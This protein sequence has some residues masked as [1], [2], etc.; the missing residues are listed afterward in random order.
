MTTNP[1]FR[2]LF[3]VLIALGLITIQPCRAGESRVAPGNWSELSAKA[4]AEYQ[5]N[6]LLVSPTKNGARLN[7]IFQKLEGEVTTKGLWLSSKAFTESGDRF[8]V[9]ARSFG[10][11][12]GPMLNLS[13]A[14][15]VQIACKLVRFARENLI[16][17]YST[18]IDGI[19]QDFI[20]LQK[21]GG[22]GDLRVDLAVS[23]A[24][25]ETAPDG[26]RL[27]LSNSGRRIMYGQVQ[28]IDAAGKLLKCRIQQLSDHRIAALIDDSNALYPIRVDP[29]FSDENWI[30]ANF[31]P[32]VKANYAYA[33]TTDGAGNVYVGGGAMDVAGNAVAN[34]VAK[35]D[36]TRWSGL[37]SG[38]TDTVYAL[39]TVG[40][41]VYAG[42]VFTSAGG[43]PAS[44]IAKWDGTAWSAVGGGFDNLVHSLV[45]DNGI[46]Y[47][48]GYFSFATNSGTPVST[49]YIAKWDGNNWSAVGKGL[50]A[51]VDA[52]TVLSNSIYPVGQFYEATNANNSVLSTLRI[53]RWD[54]TNW[55]ALGS[56]LNGYGYSV[57]AMAG[58]I[59]VGGEFTTAGGN[60]AKNVAKW[61]GSSWS[62][63]GTGLN[64][65]V[66]GLAAA[67]TTLYAGG[68]FTLAGATSVSRMAKWDGVSWSALET[69]VENTV[70]SLAAFGNNVYAAGQFRRAGTNGVSMVAKWNG[71]WSA[72]GSGFNHT[73]N[74]LMISQ[75]EIYASGNFTTA[76]GGVLASRIAK[77]N[78]TT[79]SPL[80]PGIDN[81][82]GPMIMFQNRLYV[83]GAI[84]SPFRNLGKWDGTNW[85]SVGGGVSGIVSA[86]H[87]IGNNLYVSGQF[88]RVTNSGAGTGLNVSRIARW[89]GTNWFSLNGGVDNS[90]NSL[91]SNGSDLYLGGGFLNGTNGN[92]PISLTRV[93]KWDGT[94]FSALGGG[95]DGAPLTMAAWKNDIYFGGFFKMATN[96]GN[97][98]GVSYAAKWNGTSFVALGAGLSSYVA[99]TIVGPGGV[100]FAGDFAIATNTAGPVLVNRIARWDGNQWWPLGSG[101]NGTV[102]C[103]ATSGQYLYA[104]GAFGTAGGKGSAYFAKAQVLSPAVVAV[105]VFK[106]N[107]IDLTLSGTPNEEYSIE[108][109][110]SLGSTWTP[111]GTVT[112]DTNGVATFQDTSLPTGPAFYRAVTE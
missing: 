65:N 25:V 21:A 98:V 18:S 91:T 87:V 53:A 102:G 8:Q 106:T 29:T 48:G 92:T 55:S 105:P 49:S 81:I 16:E 88:Q 95:L 7:C 20:V 71:T 60:T 35:W 94:N 32:G 15:A 30:S 4:E 72:L 14:G 40:N 83:G 97:S 93:A 45:V 76:P 62:A 5:G 33:V 10:R 42:G 109:T 51:P 3:H 89:D 101:M 64:G 111:I 44:C 31:L 85:S 108:R 110:L 9:A 103:L 24:R 38:I 104:S 61:D 46:V 19:R 2:H 1:P 66:Y 11:E 59:Y 54:G 63:L 17:E 52:L 56:G 99:T 68:A 74:E 22:V 69:G 23:G 37:G 80:G 73:V 77:W 13:E 26:I 50:N 36:G 12:A 34:G 6:G 27:V 67:G 78:G 90:V 84:S 70:N 58:N 47:A 107:K 96:S 100:Y 112:P 82:S 28:V 86:L 79:W 43:V 39:A 41:D 75:T 57:V